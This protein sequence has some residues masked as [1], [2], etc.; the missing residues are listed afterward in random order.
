MT[1]PRLFNLDGQVALITGSSRGIGKAI[2]VTLAAAGAKVVVSSRKIEA[3]A[4][5]AEIITAAGGT[6]MAMAC[7]VSDKGQRDALVDA[8]Q[9]RLG[10]ISILVC[11]AAVNPAYGPLAAL[12]DRAFDKVMA[13]NVAAN[14]HL[15]NRVAPG[16]AAAGGGAV[17][18]L[19]SIAG[20]MGS[21]NIGAYAVSK[22]ADAQLARNYAVELGRKNIR[23]NAVAPGLIRT[24]FSTALWEGQRGADFVARTPLGRLGEA[25]DVAGVVLF[26]ASKASS[27]VTGQ[28]IVADGGITIADPF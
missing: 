7:N 25:E 27:Y 21:Q 15:I 22:A 12:E 13:V 11:N 5:V 18:L 14:I 9:N 8:A 10:P 17:I 3:C 19:S 16:M 23:V 28:V 26:L 4:D 24:E 6:A 20:M 2:A 1:S